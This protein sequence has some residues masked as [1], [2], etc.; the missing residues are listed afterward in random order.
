MN[1]AGRLHGRSAE[2]AI[3]DGILGAAVERGT[4]LVLT[5]E[6]GVGKSA[7]LDA[8]ALRAS[9]TGFRVLRVVGSQFGERVGFSALNQILQPLADE[10]PALPARQSETLQAVRGLSDGQPAEL[11]AIA[12][13]VRVLLSRAATDR[14][15]LA[16]WWTACQPEPSTNPPCTRTMFFAALM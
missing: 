14:T 11:L 6:A 1:P 13:A 9:E 10:I 5:G 8:A 16:W 4:A 7:L 15:P 12:N 3:I 2:L